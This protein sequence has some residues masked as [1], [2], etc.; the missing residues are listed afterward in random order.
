MSHTKFIEER[1]AG[2]LPEHGTTKVDFR[3]WDGTV[4]HARVLHAKAKL[5]KQGEELKRLDDAIRRVS[6]SWSKGG[7]P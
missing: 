5:F 7:A 6:R 3:T 4:A 2:I 1:A